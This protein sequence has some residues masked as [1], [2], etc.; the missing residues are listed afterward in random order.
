MGQIK[1]IKLHIVTDIKVLSISTIR[2]WLTFALL[3]RKLPKQVIPKVEKPLKR[4]S[5][6][7]HRKQIATPHKHPSNDTCELH[8]KFN[9]HVLQLKRLQFNYCPTSGS[10]RGLRHFLDHEAHKFLAANPGVAVY[11]E[12]KRFKAP[13]FTATYMNGEQQTVQL[14]NHDDTAIWECVQRVRDQ[15]G[16]SWRT[17]RTKQPWISTNPSIQGVWNPFM[18]KPPVDV[19]PDNFLVEDEEESDNTLP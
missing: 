9:R 18:Y 15:S 14:P 12:E 2:M 11:V 5:L 1:N 13:A 8:W 6:R 7:E 19:N 10:S 4:M 16:R 17:E 3:T